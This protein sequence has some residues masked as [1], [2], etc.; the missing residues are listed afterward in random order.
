MTVHPCGTAVRVECLC[1]CRPH[2]QVYVSS[3]DSQQDEGFLRPEP[4]HCLWQPAGE[5]VDPLHHYFV[6]VFPVQRRVL[7]LQLRRDGRGLCSRCCRHSMTFCP[8]N[9]C[10]TI[11][12]KSVEGTLYI[13]WHDENVIGR[14]RTNLERGVVEMPSKAASPVASASLGRNERSGSL[15]SLMTC[16]ERAPVAL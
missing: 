16:T 15:R 2:L 1:L 9:A 12:V 4:L 13:Q 5:R 10:R 11:S 8:A 6:H 3:D 7:E 14:E